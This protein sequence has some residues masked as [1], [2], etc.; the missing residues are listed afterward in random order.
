MIR[1][2]ID[3][4][5]NRINDLLHQVH[6]L[7]ADIRP[8][9]FIQGVKKYKDEEILKLIKDDNN[10]IYVY[11]DDN[12][13]VQGYAFLNFKDTTGLD[14]LVYRKELYIDDLCVDSSSRGQGIGKKLYYFVLDLAKSLGFYHVTLN[15]WNGNDSAMAFYKSIGLKPLKIYMEKIL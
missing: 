9:I 6:Q 14:S 3:S 8:D 11:T 5:L 12:D 2:A 10:P 1:R 7:H 13:I 4:D 15:V